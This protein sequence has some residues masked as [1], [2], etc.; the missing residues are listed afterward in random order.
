MEL[1]DTGWR[2]WWSGQLIRQ[3]Q[4]NEDDGVFADSY[5]IP[6]YFGGSDLEYGIMGRVHLDDGT[7]RDTAFVPV[8]DAPHSVQ[9]DGKRSTLFDKFESRRLN[10]IVP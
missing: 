10:F 9:L 2:A 3:L 8:S 7:F 5:S 1:D 6:N 4:D